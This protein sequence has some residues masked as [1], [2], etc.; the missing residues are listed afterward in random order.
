MPNKNDLS[1]IIKTL[2]EQTSKQNVIKE[3]DTLVTTL[4]NKLNNIKINIG[5]AGLSQLV[6]QLNQVTS[7]IQK[8]KMPQF[9]FDIPTAESKKFL[10]AIGS[11]ENTL[12]ATGRTA[13]STWD[14][15]GRVTVQVTNTTKGLVENFKYQWDAV[16]QSL[17]RVNRQQ[18]DNMLSIDQ[19]QA[20]YKGMVNTLQ[21][22]K[23][24]QSINTSELQAFLKNLKDVKVVDGQITAE[25]QAQFNIMKQNAQMTRDQVN[26][27]K[28]L[29]EQIQVLK[30]SSSNSF[31]QFENSKS[32]GALNSSSLSQY[33]SIKTS[34]SSITELTPNAIQALRLLGKQFDELKIKAN[35]SFDLRNAEQTLNNYIV[36]MQGDIAKFKKQFEGQFSTLKFNTFE[37]KALGLQID[38]NAS[39]K[40]ADLTAKIKALNNEFGSMKSEAYANGINAANKATMSFGQQIQLIIQ[41]FSMW[42]GISTVVMGTLH[43]ITESFDYMLEQTKL[44]TNL[45]MEMTGQ[46]LNFSEITKAAQEYAQATGTLSSEVMRA[47]SVFGTYT[48]KIDEVIHKSQAAVIMSNITG[49][50]I[51][52]ISDDLMSTAFQYKMGAD[53]YLHIVD[54]YASVAR[55]LQVDFP[56]AVAELGSGLKYV[57]AVANSANM[58]ITNVIASL[59]VLQESTRRTGSQVANGMKTIISRLS[60]VG[61]EIDPESFKKVEKV[62]YDTTGVMLKE[63][64]DNLKP[65]NLILSELAEKW[66][67]LGSVQKAQLAESAAGIYQRNIFISLMENYSKIQDLE[68]EAINSNGVALQKQDIYSKSLFASIQRLQN[69]FQGLYQNTLSKD[70]MKGTVDS[71]TSVISVF[72]ELSETIGGLPA[73]ITASVLAISALSSK[74][75]NG[76]YANMLGSV[77]FKGLSSGQQGPAL[78]PGMSNYSV[79]IP[80]LNKI[81][82]SIKQ[83]NTLGNTKINFLDSLSSFTRNISGKAINSFNSLKTSII[84]TVNATKS[85][86]VIGTTGKMFTLLGNGIK[87]T[88]LA[89]GQ[90]ITITN[91]AKVATIGLQTVMSMGMM[92]AFSL[93]IG[94]VFKLADSFIHAKE[95]QQELFESLKNDVSTLSSELS[96]S[97]K[98]IKTYNDLSQATSLTSEEKEK[99]ADAT[100]KLSAL[101]PN[102]IEKISAEGNAI[103]LNSEKLQEYLDLKEQE[104]NLKR[105]EMSEQFYKTGDKDVNN[106]LINEKNIK[107][108]MDQLAEYEKN[109]KRFLDSGDAKTDK[110]GYKKVLEDISRTKKELLELKSESTKFTDELKTKLTATLQ[111]QDGFKDFKPQELDN[112][113]SSLLKSQD[114]LEQIKKSGGIEIFVANLIDN[115]FA[116]TFSNINKEFNDLSKNTNKTQQD[117]DDFNK[118]S[119]SKLTEKLSYLGNLVCQ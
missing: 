25:L 90:Y 51:L 39:N 88:T 3:V 115:G 113:V 114:V 22:G 60:R 17:V 80:I 118:N 107:S 11:I 69:A 67:T 75:R 104:L 117:I 99:L 58:P 18:Q 36:K 84:N 81:I 112:F 94:Q 105:Q 70:F 110:T 28:T 62:V 26:S 57:G 74:T 68:T 108:K 7:A 65:I 35:Q 50:S 78:P 45:Q 83:I 91:L 49:K 31:K 33:N 63:S 92:V 71:T 5:G 98:L 95:K 10:T 19:L 96:D 102:S 111:N 38:P 1:I 46:N 86:G 37:Q 106:L 40:T 52:E 100:E 32:F 30:V 23:L 56:K 2:I 66:K 87:G 101:Y 20:K 119:I 15:F 21:I 103:S 8:I 9:N 48:S 61:D 27:A 64:E 6:S 79:Q 13:K 72:S 73:L 54:M 89:L 76:Y 116:S 42:I 14:E 77:S 16:N 34:I 47:I 53:Q 93:V 4:Q 29:K 59:G 12:N 55:N 109:Q 43:R 44:F 97:E 85:L 82:S 41:K 24:G